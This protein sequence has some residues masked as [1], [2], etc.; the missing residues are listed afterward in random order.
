MTTDLEA[1]AEA[2]GIKYFLVSFTDLMGVQRAKL[3]PRSA[4]MG[5]ARTGAAFAGFATWLDMTPADPD[6]LV[7]ADPSSLIQLPWKPEIGWLAGDP[8]M[9]GRPVA[10]APRVVLQRLVAEAASRG[11]VMQTGVECE[12]FLIAADGTAIADGAELRDPTSQTRS[13]E[14]NWSRSTGFVM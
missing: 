10:Q 14:N 9:S 8:W 11:Y 6:M 5:M 4:I 7:M 13:T 1:R 2:L 3:V 12:F